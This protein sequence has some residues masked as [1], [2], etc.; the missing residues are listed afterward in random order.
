[1]ARLATVPDAGAIEIVIA[2]DLEASV[3]KRLPAEEASLYSVRRISGAVGAKTLPRDDGC[4]IIV[5][6]R[7]LMPGIAA[8]AEIDVLRMFEHEAWHVALRRRDEDFYSGVDRLKPTGAW[9]QYVGQALVLIDESRVERAL[10]ERGF[11]LAPSYISST[12]ETLTACAAAMLDAI[13]NRYPGEPVTRCF[14]TALQAFNSL[15]THLSYLAA[16]AANVA[17]LRRLPS[18]QR[19][20]GEHYDALVTRLELPPSAVASADADLLD[21]T[22]N[23]VGALLHDWLEYVGFEIRDVEG[24]LYFDV[25]RHDFS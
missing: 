20:V 16:A 12:K 1:M 15:T 25:L 2:G 6:S 19:L 18:W 24:Y 21:A 17:D 14:E 11:A 3:K 13:T 23:D 10:L 5:D 4:A 7:L 8:G 22:T 9:A